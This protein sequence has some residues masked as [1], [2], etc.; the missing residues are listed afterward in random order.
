V[1]YEETSFNNALASRITIH[2]LVHRLICGDLFTV[3]KDNVVYMQLLSIKYYAAF[4]SEGPESSLTNAYLP[5]LSW[6]TEFFIVIT[7]LVN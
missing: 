2:L 7:S 1:K 3:A 4:F 6:Y 5:L